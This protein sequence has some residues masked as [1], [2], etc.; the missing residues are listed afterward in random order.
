MVV[1]AMEEARVVDMEVVKVAVLV[2]VKAEEAK[3]VDL[4]EAKEA[5]LTVDLT[6]VAKDKV[7]TKEVDLEADKEVDKEVDLGA[8]KEVVLGAVKE[9]DKVDLE[10]VKEDKVD[11]KEADLAVDKEDIKIPVVSMHNYLEAIHLYDGRVADFV[12]SKDSLT[13]VTLNDPSNLM[14]QG[15]H[16]KDKVPIFTKRGKVLYDSE[17]YMDMVEK[18]RPDM[19][20]ILSDGD[21]NMTSS[22][23]RVSKAVENTVSFNQ[24]CIE[25]HKKSEKLKDAFVIAPIAGGYC[26]K[27]RKQCLELLSPNEPDV[28]GY[29]I[30]G[31]HNNGPEVELISFSEVKPIVD[32]VISKLPP[33]KLRA[34]Q[35]CWSPL[36]IIKLVNSGID[37]F[38]TSYCRILTERSA[39]LTF[40]IDAGEASE[41]YEINLRHGKFSEDFQPVLKECKCVAC[42]GYS[43]A[44]IHHLLTVQEL[45]GSVLIMVHNIHHMLRFF[46]KIRDSVREDKLNE[47]EDRIH[48]LVSFLALLAIIT[49]IQA[50]PQPATEWD[51]HN[52]P[53]VYDDF[54][55]EVCQFCAKLTKSPI[56]YPM[57][58]NSED[59]VYEWC[60][61][62]I[63][64]GGR[65]N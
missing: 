52:N 56:V 33:G 23:K 20:I 24:R 45:L 4:A 25:R 42:Q 9:V 8:V 13:C 18:L 63:N 47:L 36:N 7:G 39:A 1:A 40:A 46:Q 61:K 19:Y 3:A 60:N 62:Y 49:L 44:Y 5:A 14:K 51:R 59:N 6:A 50:A 11:T 10:A 41:S 31:L 12:G 15:H 53:C 38:D 27:S 48:L 57:C 35:G 34:I 2:E 43:R 32:Y 37:I 29:L 28:Q 17:N 55:V 64:Y 58:C 26:V 54:K 21:T 30:D 16:N 65:I 22:N